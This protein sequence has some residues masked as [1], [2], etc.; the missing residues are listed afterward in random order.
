M[1]RVWSL[2]VGGVVGGLCLGSDFLLGFWP[3]HLVIAFWKGS[4]SEP[5]P[6]KIRGRL[7]W[8]MRLS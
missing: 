7:P 8:G 1:I 4:L 5:E 3:W 6:G 2:G